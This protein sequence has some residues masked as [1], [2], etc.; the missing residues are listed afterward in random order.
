MGYNMAPM[1][2]MVHDVAVAALSL[3]SC[4][5]KTC[6]AIWSM[7]VALYTPTLNLTMHPRGGHGQHNHPPL[8]RFGFGLFVTVTTIIRFV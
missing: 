7:V 6:P 4:S 1:A 8:G 2:I 5:S 3:L